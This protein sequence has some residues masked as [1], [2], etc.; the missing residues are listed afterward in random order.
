LTL[1]F[2][3]ENG[4]LVDEIEIKSAEDDSDAISRSVRHITGE[5][6]TDLDRDSME[7]AILL[8]DGKI[9]HRW[10]SSHIILLFLSS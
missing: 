2:L 4:K 3:C 6:G 8:K 9:I 10:N 7:E 1:K 5:T